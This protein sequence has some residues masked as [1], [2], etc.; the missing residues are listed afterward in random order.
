[1][2]ELSLYL[3]KS[4]IGVIVLYAFYWCFLKQETFFSLNRS[5]L[6]LSLLVSFTFPL[7][8]FSFGPEVKSYLATGLP[9][10]LTITIAPLKPDYQAAN[11]FD[12][13][14]IVYLAGVTFFLGRVL[15]QLVSFFIQYYSFPKISYS[16]FTVVINKTSKSPASFFSILFLSGQDL[17]GGHLDTII[18]HENYH[19]SQYHSL[20]ILW[21]EILTAFQW[22]NP[23]IWFYKG[24]LRAQHEYAA[25][26]NMIKQGK[27]KFQYQSLLFEIGVGINVND[28]MSYFNNSLLK[29][30]MKMMNKKQ[31]K[32]WV[33]LKY[34]FAL[35]LIVLLTVGLFS[36]Q[37]VFA[38]QNIGLDDQVGEMPVYPGGISEMFNFIRKNIKYPKSARRSGTQGKVFVSF[39]VDKTG[40]VTNIK[41]DEGDYKQNVMDEIVVIAYLKEN[42]ATGADK[43]MEAIITEAKYVVS[44]L[45]HFTPGKKGGKNVD[46]RIT[47]PITFRTDV[48]N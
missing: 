47:I 40:K 48:L 34:L 32:P 46:V 45:A 3:L 5:Y 30:R 10:P 35:P 16:G 41:A 28:L 31:S 25:D 8:N 24:A 44:Q 6:L 12:V 23:F 9:V 2:S 29:K 36:D 22:F 17:K 42:V 19:R 11:P 13:V 1:M 39:V 37:R 20:D 33:G 14:K 15:W 7:L 26:S 38:Q 21:I 4:A 43:D 18:S 27:D